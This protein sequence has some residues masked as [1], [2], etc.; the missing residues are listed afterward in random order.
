MV[1]LPYENTFFLLCMTPVYLHE[2]L[3]RTLG[4]RAVFSDFSGK[5]YASRRDVKEAVADGFD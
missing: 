4:I 3:R 2:A 1:N 5:G